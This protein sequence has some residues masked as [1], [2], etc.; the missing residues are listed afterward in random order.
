VPTG[1]RPLG[2]AVANEIKT[3]WRGYLCCHADA[4]FIT[5]LYSPRRAA[6]LRIISPAACG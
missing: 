6:Q 3:G 1:E 5:T 2:F 4:L